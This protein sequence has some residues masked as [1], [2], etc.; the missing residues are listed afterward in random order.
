VGSAQH[1]EVVGQPLLDVG[2]S[3]THHDF[4]S[5]LLERMPQARPNR[6][7]TAVVQAGVNNLTDRLLPLQLSERVF[8]YAY[9][10]SVR[11]RRT[12]CS[13]LAKETL[14][15]PDRKIYQP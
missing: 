8:R 9:R 1:V 10:A 6:A 7:M 13:H 15:A 2:S 4:D 5:E 12:H 11:G 14:M 3:A